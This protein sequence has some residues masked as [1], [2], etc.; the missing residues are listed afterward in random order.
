MSAMDQAHHLLSPLQGTVSAVASSPRHGFSKQALA[1]IRLLAGEGVEGD[2]HRGTTVQHLYQK[3]RDPA[4]PNLSQVH[5][6]AAEMLDELATKGFALSPGELGE[7]VLTR[8]LDLLQLPCGTQLHLGS[9]AVVQLTGLRT[10]CSLIDKPRRGLQ[11][12][13]WGTVS[14]GS[15]GKGRTRRAGVMAIVLASGLVH[16][17]DGIHLTLPP[18]PHR[19]LGP[20]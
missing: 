4:Q 15:K 2:A 1:S 5:L 6:F 18:P 11:Q 8:G 12:H 16:A 7:N 20:V 14:S 10:P 9:D 19:A 17:G 13:L 3:R